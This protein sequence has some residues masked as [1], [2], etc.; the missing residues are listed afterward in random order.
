MSSSEPSERWLDRL[1]AP[2]TRRQ[3]FTKVVLTAA[4]FTLPLARA[5]PALADDPHACRKGCNWTAHRKYVKQADACPIPA[6]AG[7]SL[8]WLYTVG[9]S[10]GLAVWLLP[11][12]LLA[13]HHRTTQCVEEALIRQKAS[14]FDCSQPGCAGFDP[15][16]PG[17]P[18]EFIG[19]N[20]CC[21]CQASDTGY[22]PCVFPCSD[23]TH[24]CCPGG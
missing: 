11:E 2:S 23:P 9:A 16:Q 17:G 5:K 1:A 21:T 12:T 18:C 22:I 14:Y 4:A 8:G 7:T 13:A 24:S 19:N 10:P 3:A 20:Y 15:K 6:A